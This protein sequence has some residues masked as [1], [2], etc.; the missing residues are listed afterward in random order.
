MGA[1][2]KCPDMLGGRMERVRPPEHKP[3]QRG[4]GHSGVAGERAARGLGVPG[5][6]GPPSC[7]RQRLLKDSARTKAQRPPQAPP[8]PHPPHGGGQGGSSESWRPTRPADAH[9]AARRCLLG[10]LRVSRPPD[11]GNA[12]TTLRVQGG[13]SPGYA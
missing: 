13:L 5:P 10:D 8:L 6:G 9:L 12:G 3:T 11:T 4:L 1:S 7:H 2:R